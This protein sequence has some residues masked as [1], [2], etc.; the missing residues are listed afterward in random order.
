MIGLLVKLRGLPEVKKFEGETLL[1][2][3]KSARRTGLASHF[4]GTKL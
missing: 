2:L 1:L 4:I 3:F